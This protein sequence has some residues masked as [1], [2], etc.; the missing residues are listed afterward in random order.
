MAAFSEK[1]I[2]LKT[3]PE[4]EVLPCQPHCC[5]NLQRK[6][7]FPSYARLVRIRKRN[8][9]GIT[10]TDALGISITAIAFHRD[11]ILDIEE[12]MAKG[13][14]NDACSTPD[15]QFFID[16]DPII[17]FRFPMA[18]LCWAHLHAIG[19]FTVIAGHRKMTHTLP[20]DYFNPGAAWIDCSCMK[21]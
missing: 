4:Q 16:G 15:A 13:A 3:T 19:F 20:V 17:I 14:G 12:G 5:V 9:L 18:G 8:G 21:Q 11:P 7:S 2:G 6:L 1:C 10:E